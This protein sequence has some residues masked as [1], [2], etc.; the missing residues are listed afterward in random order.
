M[1]CDITDQYLTIT[2]DNFTREQQNILLKLKTSTDEKETK[3]L[4]K[5]INCIHILQV[6]LLKLK[7]LKNVKKIKD[8]L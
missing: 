1:N 4:T 5:Q 8:L 7:S 3:E 2:Y 6:N